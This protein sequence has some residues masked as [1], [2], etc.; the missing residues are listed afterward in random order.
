MEFIHE[1][2]QVTTSLSPHHPQSSE[3]FCK[4]LTFG[5]HQKCVL[6]CHFMIGFFGF[7]WYVSPQQSKPK[8]LPL[9]LL[10]CGLRDPCGSKG[11][12]EATAGT[13]RPQKIS[14]TRAWEAPVL[15]WKRTRGKKTPKKT[16][17][18]STFFG[19]NIRY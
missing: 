11:G 16:W 1:T 15:F 5:R 14:T 9:G 18:W 10:C 13:A 12:V 8:V 19:E 4:K 17:R 7:V 2:Q 3:V 6:V